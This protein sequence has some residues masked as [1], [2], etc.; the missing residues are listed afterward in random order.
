MSTD[1][2]NLLIGHW[3]HAARGHIIITTRREVTEIGEETGIEEKCCV[4]LKCLTEDEGIQF[5][6]LGTGKVL[7]E[8][9]DA[10]ELIRELGGLPLA[11]DQAGAYIRGLNQSITEYLKKYKKQKLLLLK[12]KKD[13]LWKTPPLSG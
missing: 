3:K 2:Q 8:E 5:L 11:L 9:S 10:Q 13:I 1:M 4:V 6:R 7:G 12:K